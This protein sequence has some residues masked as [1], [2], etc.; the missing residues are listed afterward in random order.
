MADLALRMLRASPI[1]RVVGVSGYP[2]D[3]SA[4]LAEAPGRV[5]FLPKPFSPEM[6][7]SLVERMLGEEED[8]TI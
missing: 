5:A 2:V 8:K 1:L 3:I 4:L 6:L 7:A